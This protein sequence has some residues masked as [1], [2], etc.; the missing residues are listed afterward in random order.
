MN[1]ARHCERQRSNPVNKPQNCGLFLD[2]HVAALLAMTGT[3]YHNLI[4][5]FEKRM[6]FFPCPLPRDDHYNNKTPSAG[7]GVDLA[8]LA[9]QF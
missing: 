2:C 1:V 6:L 5:H 8:Y 4:S 3:N 9:V 7:E